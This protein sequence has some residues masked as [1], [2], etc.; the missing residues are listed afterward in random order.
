MIN[1]TKLY[2]GSCPAVFD[3]RVGGG[4]RPAFVVYVDNIGILGTDEAGVNAAM[5]EVEALLNA[6][7]LTT[8]EKVFAAIA[9][10]ALGLQH[11]MRGERRV[12]PR[13]GRHRAFDAFRRRLGRVGRERTRA[14]GR[15]ASFFRWY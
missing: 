1:A 2:D 3:R 5:A 14:R 9:A 7:G 6:N 11:A 12:E 4:K 13:G 8:H 15:V 10:E